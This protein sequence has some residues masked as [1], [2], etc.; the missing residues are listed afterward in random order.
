[1]LVLLKRRQWLWL[2]LVAQLALPPAADA[3]PKVPPN[4]IDPATRNGLYVKDI[5]VDWL[6]DDA[7][8]ATSDPNYAANKAEMIETLTSSVRDQFLYSP[9]G[10]NA[11]ALHIK[12]KRFHR[13]EVIADVTVVR[14][15]DQ[16]ELGT[17]EGIDG[18]YIAV[19]AGGGLTGALIGMSSVRDS[20]PGTANC[21]A[22][23]LRARFNDLPIPRCS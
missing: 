20:T 11:V 22:M 8:N 15:A 18:Y 12:L 17:Y 1:M 23:I 16:Q 14:T 6:V 9:S 5:V 4:P 10:P 3:M 2:A 13:Y 19:V 7:K 21:F